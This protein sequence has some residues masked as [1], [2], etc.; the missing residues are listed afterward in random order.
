[1]SSS[2]SNYIDRLEAE[3]DRYLN[4]WLDLRRV[5]E[6]LLNVYESGED[7]TGE[8]PEIVALRE[9]LR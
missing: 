5:A 6:A 8:I 4:R 7:I 1:M 3:R 2:P 9:A